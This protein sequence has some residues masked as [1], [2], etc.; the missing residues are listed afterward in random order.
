M[1]NG[2]DYQSSDFP[3]PNH[4]LKT[5]VDNFYFTQ[6]YKYELGNKWPTWDSSY[7]TLENIRLY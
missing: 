3:N 5:K 4:Y 6:I 7:L 1:P 2:Y